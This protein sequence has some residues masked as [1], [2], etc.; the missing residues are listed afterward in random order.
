MASR[1]VRAQSANRTAMARERFLTLGSAHPLPVREPILASW[2]RSR[3]WNVP[4]DRTQ[5]PYVRDPDPDTPLTRRAAPV[6]R[7]LRENLGGQPVS[8]ILADAA[9]VVLSRLTADEDLERHLDEVMLA[10][11]FS[12]AEAS[13]GTN[14]LGTALEGGQP[15]HVFGPEHYAQILADLAS[16]GIPIHHPISGRLAGAV[17]LTCWRRYADQDA[18]PLLMA[19]VKTTADQITQALSHGLDRARA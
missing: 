13:V 12:Y 3:E 7:Q 9:G 2:R 6:L 1:R 15:A 5:V 4:A 17:G 11:G 14:G 18:A 19:L 8:V 16:A 10:P